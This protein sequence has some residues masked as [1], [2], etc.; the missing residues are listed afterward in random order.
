MQNSTNEKKCKKKNDRSVIKS[1][2]N[3]YFD[4]KQLY[5]GCFL[6]SEWY[7]KANLNKEALCVK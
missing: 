6:Y 2:R 5:S 7:F 3:E 1:E 4:E